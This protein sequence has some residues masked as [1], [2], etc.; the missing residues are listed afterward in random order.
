MRPPRDLSLFDPAKHHLD[1]LE[2]SQRAARATTAH[3]R[4]HFLRMER[5]SL[6]LARNAEWVRSNDKF[7]ETW[8]PPPD[9]FLET[10]RPRPDK[11]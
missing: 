11:R 2:F 3:S 4:E 10:W 5:T 8:R 1:A 6:L 7:L 9:K